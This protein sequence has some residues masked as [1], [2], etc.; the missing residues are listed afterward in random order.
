MQTAVIYARYSS[1][2]Q[3]EQSIE[4]QLRV[5]EEYAKRNDII[6]LNTYIDRAMTGRNDN[7]PDFQRMLKDNSRKEW[8]FII[9]YKFDRFAR[10]RYETA[11]HKKELKDNGVKVLSAMENIPDTPEAIIFES[12]LEGYAEYYSAELAQKVKRGMFETRRKGL[13][14]GG[15]LLYGYKIDGRKIV[16]DENN[17][18]VVRF[19]YEQYANG[20][21]VKDIIRTL[22]EKNIFYK[23]KPFVRNS[24]YN[25]L[26]NEKYSG[27][28]KHNDEIVDN[29]YPQIVPTNI[30]N[31]V[32]RKVAANKYGKKSVKADFLLRQKLICGN[33][34]QPMCGESGTT[35]NGSRIYYYKCYGRKKRLNDCNK[36]MIRK[37][38]IENLVT[39]TVVQKLSEPNLINIIVSKILQRQ[40]KSICE[41][42]A[43]SLLIKQKKQVDTAIDNIVAAIERGIVT[44]ATNK[45]LQSLEAQQQELERQILIE[46]SKQ[47]IKISA[48]DIKQFYSSALNENSKILINLLIEKIILF[49]DKVEIYFNKP[50][51]NPNGTHSGF[52][53]CSETVEIIVS[54]YANTSPDTRQLLLEI[55][56]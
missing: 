5:C 6:I 56:I 46:R 52:I 17:A 11:I 22:T 1:D 28:Y 2:S 44:N 55:I 34:G 48:A 3:N 43:L 30:F 53:L 50:I 18:A 37:E 19:M 16:I 14:Q 25:I 40:E 24:V 29:M 9:V 13:Y 33:C 54:K 51:K 8:N 45:R 42:S 47:S 39:D 49:D 41:N 26:R 12:M 4:G 31:Q 35:K 7:R 36:A 32:R 38:V 15:G 20:I 10:N 23:G 27:V 21:F